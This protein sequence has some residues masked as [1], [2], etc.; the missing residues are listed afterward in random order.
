MKCCIYLIVGL[1]IFTPLG[2]AETKSEQ[3]QNKKTTPWYESFN[4]FALKMP[5]N[6]AGD[7]T[8][9]HGE[10][11]RVSSDTKIDVERLDSGKRIQGTIIMIS[12]RVLATKGLE[13][14]RGY[15]IDAYDGPVLLL[16]LT[17]ELLARAF[18]DGPKSIKTASKINLTETKDGINVCTPSASADFPPPFA[19]TGTA[20]KSR[21]GVVEFDLNLTSKE[22]AKGAKPKYM[23][24]IS[25]SLSAATADPSLEES[26]KLDDWKV[27][28][29]GPITEKRDNS[30][31]LDYG[32]TADKKQHKTVG[33]VRKQIAEEMSPGIA[34]TT[35]D[36]TGFWK[37]KCDQNFGLQIK[38]V[39]ATGM[40][41]V[42]FCGPGGCFEPGTYR[43]NT[44][45]NKDKSYEV[46]S[47]D[48]IK[49]FGGDGWSLYKKCSSNPNPK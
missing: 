18:P 5:G 49:V 19:L 29:V 7:Y 44:Y 42:S 20:N 46:I 14:D 21:Q 15:E 6:N 8:S 37:E 28:G 10:Y 9:W 40:Y 16:N 25:G 3:H 33:D 32:A 12:G 31:I 47:S 30:T 2:F 26:M 34:D 35:H 11:S 45:I 17:M 36:F 1:L 48:E 39:G 13:L 4:T 41:T 24:K 27:Y 22:E 43:P 23:I 38:P